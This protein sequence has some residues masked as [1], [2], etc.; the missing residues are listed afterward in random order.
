V[1]KVQLTI[2]HESWPCKIA[3]A[4]NANK[5]V[6]MVEQR[7]RIPANTIEQVA[8]GMQE[9]TPAIVVG[10]VPQVEPYVDIRAAQEAEQL[11]DEA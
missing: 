11:L 7:P 5:R 10:M 4:N 3:A 6:Q 9:I 8:L 1:D 2:A